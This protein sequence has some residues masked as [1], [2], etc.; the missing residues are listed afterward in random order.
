M[1]AEALRAAAARQ[2]GLNDDLRAVL[3]RADDVRAEDVGVVQL[4]R[5]S[6]LPH[7]DV[8]MVERDSGD[9]DAHLP[10]ARLGDRELLDAQDLGTAVLAKHDR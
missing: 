3:R 7:P 6:A 5:G 1:T 4:E 2:P 8:E 10:G 9:L